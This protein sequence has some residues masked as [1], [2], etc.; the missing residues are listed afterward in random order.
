MLIDNCNLNPAGISIAPF[1]YTQAESD[2]IQARDGGVITASLFDLYLRVNYLSFGSGPRF[3]SDAES[4][5]FT[6]FSMV[7]RSIKDSLVDADEQLPLFAEQQNLTYDPIKRFKEPWS[8]DA[9]KKARKHFRDILISLQAALDAMADLTALLLTGLIPNLTV[10][11]AQFTAV[12]NWLLRPLPPT[13][14]VLS[15]ADHHL[16]NLHETL[17]PLVHPSGADR[18]W[19]PLM[20]L[21]RNKVAHLGQPV[22]R[23]VGL[24]DTIRD[25]AYVFVPRQWPYIWERHFKARGDPTSNPSLIPQMLRGALMHQDIISFAQGLRSKVR[26]VVGAGVSVLTQ[27][28]LAFADFEPNQ[29][30]LAQLQSNSKSYDFEHFAEID[31]KAG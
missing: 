12:E 4:V 17:L 21:L 1:V 22:F 27:A 5:L 19:L 10:G 30:A 15:P 18:E 25:R 26:E 29:A 23:M 20:R 24:P 8:P 2:W 11:R 28:Y 14:L 6:Y 16:R 31:E 3:L 13:A 7:V 9:D